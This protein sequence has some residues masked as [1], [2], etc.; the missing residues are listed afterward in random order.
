MIAFAP[1]LLCLYT[2]FG[3]VKFILGNIYILSRYDK[4]WIRYLLSI[5]HFDEVQLCLPYQ[6][7]SLF[8][9]LQE[10]VFVSPQCPRNFLISSFCIE[11]HSI[12]WMHPPILYGRWNLKFRCDTTW[13]NVSENFQT[14]FPHSEKN[15]LW[16]NYLLSTQCWNFERGLFLKV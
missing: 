11:Q 5:Y 8:L 7:G 12:V 15:Q 16:Y 9:P 6:K 14:F 1:I 10:P 13:I 3:Y 2:I 4:K